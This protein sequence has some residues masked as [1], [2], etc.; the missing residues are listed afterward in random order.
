MA[1]KKKTCANGLSQ[2]KKELETYLIF[3]YLAEQT[4][5]TEYNC[6]NIW[7]GSNPSILALQSIAS[8]TEPLSL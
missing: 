1:S 3:I 8:I 6:K 4:L 5:K 7:R 2:T